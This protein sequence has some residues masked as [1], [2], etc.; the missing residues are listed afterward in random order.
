MPRDK[1]QEEEHGITA[2][3]FPSKMHNLNFNHE[4]TSDRP[5]LRNM[6]QNNS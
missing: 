5:K 4:E 6:L 1:V 2:L 3:K